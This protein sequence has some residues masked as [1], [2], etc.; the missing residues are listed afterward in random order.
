MDYYRDKINPFDLLPVDFKNSKK[1]IQYQSQMGRDSN[2]SN[3][4][5]IKKYLSP[6]EGQKQLDVGY[7]ANLVNY[8]LDTWKSEYYGID[9]SDKLINEMN[10]FVKN[11][12]IHIGGL[13]ISQVDK[14][15]FDSDFFD[16]SMAI[17]VFEYY[18]LDY[19][20]KGLQEINRALKPN[21][22]FVLDFPNKDNSFIDMMIEME[23]YLSRQVFVYD[24]SKYDKLVRK[25]FKIG[26]VDNSSLMIK[27][28]LE[29][30]GIC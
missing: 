28:Y 24:K 22:K 30:K 1:F 8:R 21:A 16:L 14:T 27:Y 19:V 17:G 29:N 18:E 26:K 10:G 2:G 11:N 12:A 15:P 23:N 13:A 20:H 9:I 3:N 7:C 25:F 5:E 4:P 6:T